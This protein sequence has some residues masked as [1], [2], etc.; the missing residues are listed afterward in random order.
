MNELPFKPWTQ[1]TKRIS[2]AEHNREMAA[3][4]RARNVSAT[5]EILVEGQDGTSFVSDDK[6]YR[7]EIT[8]GTNPYTWK[9]VSQQGT[10]PNPPP[11]YTVSSGGSIIPGVALPGPDTSSAWPWYIN[12]PTSYLNDYLSGTAID[13]SSL[14]P[15]PCYERNG[16]TTVPVGAIVEAEMLDFNGSLFF[17][18]ASRLVF[19]ARLYTTTLPSFART[20]NTIIYN[21]LGA[22][23]AIDGVTPVIGDIILFNPKT[24]NGGLWIVRWNGS[25]STYVVLDRSFGLE[26]VRQHHQAWNSRQ[27]RP[28]RFSPQ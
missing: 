28:G 11:G 23:S 8:G 3:L 1:D 12:D 19:L 6:K 14:C 5:G 16:C 24:A 22:I 10:A 17:D 9:M 13:G 7:I 15:W 21:A 2:A 20:G 27:R 18:Y 26:Y 25:A 4:E